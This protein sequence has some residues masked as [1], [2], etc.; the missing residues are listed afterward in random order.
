MQYRHGPHFYFL[1]VRHL[2]HFNVQDQTNWGLRARE[3][4]DTVKCVLVALKT[5]L[6]NSIVIK[7]LYK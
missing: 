6:H 3:P 4:L 7:K 2:K 5:Q 1:V